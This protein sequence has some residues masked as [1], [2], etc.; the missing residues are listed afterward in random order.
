MIFINGENNDDLSGK[1]NLHL[2]I[3]LGIYLSFGYHLEGH[4]VSFHPYHQ[5]RRFFPALKVRSALNQD[6]LSEDQSNRSIPFLPH[7]IG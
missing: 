4:L 2:F 1:E 6:H 3:F 5:L 7:R